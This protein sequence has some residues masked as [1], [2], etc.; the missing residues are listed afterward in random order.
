MPDRIEAA[1]K[2][3]FSAKLTTFVILTFL[4]STPFYYLIHKA[5]TAHSYSSWLMWTPGIS[6]LLT[7]LIHEKRISGL[8]WKIARPRFFV[9]AYLIPFSYVIVVYSAIWLSGLGAFNPSG[10]L[11]V[12]GGDLPFQYR[13]PITQMIA[14]VGYVISYVV[15]TTCW[16]TL[17]EEIG[18]RGLL[19]PEL[20][21]RYSF[22]A[23]SLISGGLWA[24]WHFPVL[25]FADYHNPGAPLWFGLFCFTTLVLGISFVFAWLRL[26]SGSLWVAVLLHASHNIFIQAIF[27]PMTEGNAV[28]PFLIDEFGAGLA[29]AGVILGITFWRK[30]AYLVS[31]EKGNGT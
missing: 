6:A 4:L 24:A 11:T 22:A 31:V 30:R 12:I 1:P 14:G 23:T 20:A 2:R 18:W 10:F 26:K 19:V 17:G 25:L 9:A 16:A 5:G 29:I 3:L 27:T 13:T 15:L 28:T 7:Q 8:G 21:K